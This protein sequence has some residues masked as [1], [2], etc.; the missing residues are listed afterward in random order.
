MVFIAEQ[1]I[2]SWNR[3][4]SQFLPNILLSAANAASGF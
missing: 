2:T 1:P 4:I 3:V